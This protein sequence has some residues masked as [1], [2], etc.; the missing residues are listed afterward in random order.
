MS[1]LYL[2]LL[3]QTE[4]QKALTLVLLLHVLFGSVTVLLVPLITTT[5][6][7]IMLLVRL[8]LVDKEEIMLRE[9]CLIIA[10]ELRLG[11]SL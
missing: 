2:L 6:G 7:V 3:I 5:K 4:L 1:L 10:I 8:H 11:L 9:F